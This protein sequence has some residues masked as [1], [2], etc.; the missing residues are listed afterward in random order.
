MKLEFTRKIKRAAC[1]M[2]AMS[3]ACYAQAMKAYESFNYEEGTLNVS[4]ADEANG[5]ST[6][7]SLSSINAEV[8]TEGFSPDINAKDNGNALLVQGNEWG[9][10]ERSL[11]D[12]WP[13][14]ADAEYWL[15]YLTE[16][17][18]DYAM[19]QYSG[20]VLVGQTGSNM[21]IGMPWIYELTGKFC[22]SENDEGGS[23]FKTDIGDFETGVPVWFVVKI[24]MS[25][26]DDPETVSVW[27]NPDPETEDLNA[28]EPTIIGTRQ[29]LNGGIVKMALNCHNQIQVAY[30]E[31]TLGTSWADVKPTKLKGT[32]ANELSLTCT[33]N[34]VSGSATLEYNLPTADRVK[35]TLIDAIG[36]NIRVLLNADQ[37]GG[38]QS[39]TFS[40]AGLSDGVYLCKLEAGNKTATT[41]IVVIK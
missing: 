36:Q 35:I 8:T 28:V 3:F 2:A 5:W 20:C 27:M 12:E 25:G 41:R 22:L 13:D 38:L 18:T 9:W 19:E 26:N 31:L 34:L 30:D 1:L 40:A 23:R 15:S 10:M 39:L 16:L 6:G 24:A 33:P 11:S 32:A 17:R 29:L 37:T 4:D 21:Y 14:E 7:W